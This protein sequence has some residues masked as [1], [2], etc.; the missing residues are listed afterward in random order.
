MRVGSRIGVVVVLG[1]G[2]LAVPLSAGAVGAAA[3]PVTR[4]FSINFDGSG[5]FSYNAQGANG[6]TGCYM[7]ASDG[8]RYSFDQ[9]WTVTV[10]FTSQGKVKYKAVVKSIKHVDG[11]QAFGAHGASHLI[12]KQTELPDEDCAQ[13]ST[14]QHNIGSYDC[15]S[16]KVTLTAFP[17]PQMEVQRS[18]A[19]LEF[20]GRAFLDGH[21]KYTGKDTIPGDKKG[22]ATYEDDMTYGS[23]LIPGIYDT[24]KVG[25][26]VKQLFNLKKG[27]K[28][29]AT[30][31][32]GKNTFYP[33]QSTCDSVFGK[34]NVCVIH[35]Q[36]MSA[37]FGVA[38]IK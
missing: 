10:Q 26:T 31:E 29:T 9:L 14:I 28:I 13:G 17:N 37:R 16:T 8:A 11:P 23:T 30:V 34:P 35:S 19:D 18:G 5:K 2:A 38:R 24:S 21:W 22:C 15:T 1:L 33:R 25:M 3:K 32:L 4:I 7:N 27:K 12:G 6:D 36:S 20:E